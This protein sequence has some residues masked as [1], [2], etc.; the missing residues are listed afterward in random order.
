MTYL[1]SLQKKIFFKRRSYEKMRENL[2]L[3]FVEPFFLLFPTFFFFFCLLFSSPFLLLSLNMNDCYTSMEK[4]PSSTA[5][6]KYIPL[7]HHEQ[8]PFQSFQLRPSH[9][10][11]TPTQQN[12]PSMNNT[13][14]NNDCNTNNNTNSCDLQDIILCYQSQPDLLRL[15][16]SSKLEEDKRRAEE[17]KLKAKELDLLLL[18]QQQQMMTPALASP[19]TSSSSSTIP[20][21][22][23]T[24]NDQSNFSYSSFSFQPMQQQQ[25]SMESPF[26][27]IS[28]PL[29]TVTSPPPSQRRPMNDMSSLSTSP[30]SPSSHSINYDLKRSQSN[31]FNLPDHSTSSDETN[32]RSFQ[33]PPS[34]HPASSPTSYVPLAE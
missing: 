28:H 22:S 24:S 2:I 14:S 32:Q 7:Y 31:P 27:G 20:P 11:K 15:I 5:S 6:S 13:N 18:Q 33:P 21:P 3:L 25:S 12:H 23:I 8:V 26:T 9:P 34:C 16:L 30:P 10:I 17:A 1:V 29:N 4:D 19:S